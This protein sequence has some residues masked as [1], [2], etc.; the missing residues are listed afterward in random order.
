M[1]YFY[2]LQCK[3][4]TLYCGYAKD[5]R[6]REIEHNSGK[7]SKYVRAKGGGKVVYSEKFETISEAT[8]REAQVKKWTRVK[9]LELINKPH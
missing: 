3:D 9:K 5:L 4:K 6:L 2:I 1:Y 8:K 7:G